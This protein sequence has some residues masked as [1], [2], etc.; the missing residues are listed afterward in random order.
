MSVSSLLEVKCITCAD[1]SHKSSAVQSDQSVQSD[2][3]LKL[4]VPACPES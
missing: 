2:A 1:N 4:S 3:Q